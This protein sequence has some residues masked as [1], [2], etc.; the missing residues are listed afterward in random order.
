MRHQS[1]TCCETTTQA[2][3]LPGI[4]NQRCKVHR[5]S[6]RGCSPLSSTCLINVTLTLFLHFTSPCSTN[7]FI[8]NLSPR[9]EPRTTLHQRSFSVRPSIMA[10][11]AH[12]SNSHMFWN[13]F[14]TNFHPPVHVYCTLGLCLSTPPHSMKS[15]SLPRDPELAPQHISHQK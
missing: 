1:F 6:V 8:Q 4:Q 7:N 2:H 13:L 5:E 14:F 9:L 10:R 12:T 3:K 15:S 11:Y